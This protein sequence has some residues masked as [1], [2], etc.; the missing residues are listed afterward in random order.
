VQVQVVVRF[1]LDENAT[2][3][4]VAIIAWLCMATLVPVNSSF[5]RDVA[6]SKC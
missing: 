1:M 6:L 5:Q 4:G 3:C 2:V